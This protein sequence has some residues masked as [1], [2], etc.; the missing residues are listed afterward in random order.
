MQGEGTKPAP[1]QRELLRALPRIDELMSLPEVQEAA[2]HLA[3]QEVARVARSVVQGVREA[4]LSAADPTLLD[5]DFPRNWEATMSAALARAMRRGLRPMINATGVLLHTNLGRA[6]L[7]QEALDAVVAVARGYSNLEF[8]TETGQ[9]GQRH[10]HVEELLVQLCGGEAAMVVNNNAAAVLL[11]LSTLTHGKEVVLSRG[12]MIEI[13]GSFRIP[14]VLRQ[15]GTRLVEV[16]TTNRTRLSDYEAA[17]GPDTAA[18]LKVH[19]SN[20]RIHG[21][22]QSVSTRELAPLSRR[23]GVLLLEDLGSGSLVRPQAYGLGPEPTVQE[24]LAAG[25]DLVTFSGDK[26]LGGPQIGVI[27]GNAE[28]VRRCQKHPLARALRVD[29]MTLAAL[30]AT[31]RAYVQ[32]RPE[33]IP[34][35]NMVAADADALRKR[36]LQWAARIAERLNEDGVGAGISI[37]VESAQST[38]G[39]GALPGQTLPTWVIALRPRGNHQPSVGALAAAMRRQ[40]P[41]IVGRI[42]DGGLLLDVRTVLPHEEDALV[43]GVVAA[44]AEEAW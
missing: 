44:L 6:P 34:L 17:V 18:I 32:G 35:W 39:G 21:F 23:A 30:Q 16:G 36:A 9:R 41:G 15:S 20:Y 25:A 4:I 5:D 10:D 1:W 7:S 2:R 38:I 27:V 28:L 22:A 33:E 19:P 3:P 37:V 24:A 26:L 31:L 43:A 11:V 29:K 42:E 14:D 12:E 13:G 8:D 40:D